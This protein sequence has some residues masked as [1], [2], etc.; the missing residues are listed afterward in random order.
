MEFLVD[1]NQMKEIDEFTMNHIG[2]PGMVLMEKAA[3]AVS[4]NML[5]KISKKDSIIA[6]CGTGNNGGDGVAIARILH[7]KGYSVKVF[8]IGDE[9]KGTEQFKQQLHIARNLDVNVINNAKISEY[10]VVIDAIFGVGLSKPISG[11]FANAIEEV[12]S[13][14]NLVFSV[15]LPSG[16]N[17]NTGQI[18][19]HAI[20]A[21]YTVTFGYKK[22]GMLLFPGCEYSGEII[23]ADIGFA[24]RALDEVSPN[25]FIFEEKD[26]NRLP[27]REN[28]SNK[29]TFGRVLIIAGCTTMCGACYLSAKAAYRTGAGL[30]KVLTVEENRSIIQ[31]MLPE[32]IIT[33]Y[34]SHNLNNKIEIDRIT[35]EIQWATTIV[36]GPGVGIS[37]ATELLMDLVLKNAKVPVV[38][39]ADGLTMLAQKEEYVGN[40]Q[41][42]ICEIK[43]PSNV[44]ITPHLKEMS[45]LLRCSTEYVRQNILTLAKRVTKNKEFVLVLKD[46]RTIVA[47]ENSY[48][49]NT[50]GNNGMA[51]GGS[52][53]VLTGVIAGLLANGMSMYD[54]ACYGVYLH[55]SAGDYISKEKGNYSLMASDIIEGLTK[56]LP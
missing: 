27:V 41:D 14:D 39:D 52:G 8:I 26:V 4:N 10:N 22:L 56:V 1:A 35:G 13:S 40:Q 30:V 17:A 2:I 47:K 36:F 15:D 23:T 6:I 28:R 21:D 9:K 37:S 20:R 44:I 29:G 51:T 24:K 50:S 19:D 32:A 12:N 34:Q 49:V 18:M 3:M 7:V 46:A 38:L 11:T 25:T 5:E 43:L 31:T 45:R 53:D 55:G 16:V 33:T 48:F 54:A 42:D